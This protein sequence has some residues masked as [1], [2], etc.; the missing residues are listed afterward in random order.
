M[1]QSILIPALLLI[2]LVSACS[3]SLNLS[4]AQLKYIW[5]E[6]HSLEFYEGFY[7]KLS[8][9]QRKQLMMKVAEENNIEYTALMQELKK[10]A[11]EKYSVLFY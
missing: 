3:S 4:E 10:K 7:E 9:K 1:K 2:T 11:P 8:S 6:Y 5:N